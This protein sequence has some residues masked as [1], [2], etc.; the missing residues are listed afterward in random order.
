MTRII[1]LSLRT[2]NVLHAQDTIFAAPMV[3]S[4]QFLVLKSTLITELG[5]CA[6]M[7]QCGKHT[8]F[9]IMEYL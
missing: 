9:K 7:I 8:V 2:P 1:K 6:K 3:F 4:V 5:K